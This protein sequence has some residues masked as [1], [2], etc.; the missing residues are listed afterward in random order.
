[1]IINFLNNNLGFVTFIAGITVYIV[2]INQK[3]DKKRDAARIILQEIRRAEDIISDYIEHGQ[4]KFT[5]KIIATN[6]WATNVHHFVGNL[7]HD[8][9]DRISN[10]YSMG[11]YLDSII[12]KISDY[13]FDE[14]IKAFRNIFHPQIQ[15]PIP[16]VQPVPTAQQQSSGEITPGRK[17]IEVPVALPAPWKQLLDEITLKYEPIYYSTICGKLKKIARLK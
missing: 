10:L 1:M 7:T 14:K 4:Y 13:K 12:N 5:K 17:I 9:L 6:S 2:Y 15:I 3:R 8:E 16:T 11:E